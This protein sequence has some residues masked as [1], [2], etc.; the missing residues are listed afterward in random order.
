MP[1]VTSENKAEFDEQFLR[2]KG[3]LKD[4]EKTR[5]KQMHHEQS[6][7][8]KKHPKYAKLKASLGHKGAMEAI[9]KEMNEK[10]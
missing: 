1:T 3:L 6:Q 2:Q 10:Q 8:A 7:R 4:D 9:L 5:A